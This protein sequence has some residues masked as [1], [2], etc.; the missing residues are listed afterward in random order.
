ME[1]NKYNKPESS[2]SVYNV[3][4]DYNNTKKLNLPDKI[5]RYEAEACYLHYE[6]KGWSGCKYWPAWAMGW[7]LRRAGKL[8]QEASGKESVHKRILKD[9]EV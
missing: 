4:V 8:S 6:G 2:E 1:K 9:Y 7:I 3:M 5:L